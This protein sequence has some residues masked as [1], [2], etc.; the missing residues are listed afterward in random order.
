MLSVN[1]LPFLAPNAVHVKAEELFKLLKDLRA[2]KEN[3]LKGAREPGCDLPARLVGNPS[4]ACNHSLRPREGGTNFWDEHSRRWIMAVLSTTMDQSYDE[5]RF[6]VLKFFR[7]SSSRAR[8]LV[9]SFPVLRSFVWTNYLRV[10]HP[11]IPAQREEFLELIAYDQDSFYEKG[12]T[13][14][15]DP[16]RALTPPHSLQPQPPV[17]ARRQTSA[18]S[19][20]TL[21][22]SSDSSSEDEAPL[23][24]TA[25]P[26][27]ARIPKRPKLRAISSSSS[28]P[29]GPPADPVVAPLSSSSPSGS[30][31]RPKPGQTPTVEFLLLTPHPS[32]QQQRSPGRQQPL[33]RQPPQPLQPRIARPT[34]SPRSTGS[35]KSF[36]STEIQ[37]PLGH[38]AQAQAQ[39]PALARA[40]APA[41]GPVTPSDEVGNGT[42]TTPHTR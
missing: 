40:P 3:G 22:S 11:E 23:T 41:S 26:A 9:D 29:R 34:C 32:P 19:S 1:I 25:A 36:T 6:L 30:T 10:C 21:S 24:Q 15:R 2:D 12:A 4:G 27:T 33:V 14:D 17:T 39:A 38:H 8:R 28:A 16:P 37:R 7:L 31:C 20:T 5:M 13:H 42:H 35:E 18:S